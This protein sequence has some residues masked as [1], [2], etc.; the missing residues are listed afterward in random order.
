[1]Q[2]KE[3]VQK[4]KDAKKRVQKKKRTSPLQ[5][6]EVDVGGLKKKSRGLQKENEQCG[7]HFIYNMMG[8]KVYFMNIIFHLCSF[9]DENKKKKFL[10]YDSN[11]IILKCC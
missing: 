2:K 4:K 11:L 8:D 9:F 10:F 3:A 1:M 7:I 6:R 5:G